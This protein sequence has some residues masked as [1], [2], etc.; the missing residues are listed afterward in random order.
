MIAITAGINNQVCKECQVCLASKNKI[1]MLKMQRGK[2]RRWCFLKPWLSA[3]KPTTNASAIIPYSKKE[4]WIISNPKTGRLV[5]NKGKTAQCT[6]HA[7]EAVIPIASQFIF[8]IIQ[9]QIYDSN[10]TK[11]QILC[12][13]SQVLGPGCALFAPASL[14]KPNPHNCPFV[15]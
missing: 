2:S 14:I 15:N 1:P 7:T 9:E 6:A 8:S 5:N 13:N 10:A 3:Y 11:L 4:F 12:L